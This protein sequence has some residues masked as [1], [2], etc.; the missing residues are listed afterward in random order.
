MCA[1]FKVS[2]G[3]HLVVRCIQAAEKADDGDT[4]P[5][6]NKLHRRK[7]WPRSLLSFLPHGAALTVQGL[8]QWLS[9]SPNA[10]VRSS[11]F[12]S[13]NSLIYIMHSMVITHV[14]VSRPFLDGIY[15]LNTAKDSFVARHGQFTREEE[16]HKI[17]N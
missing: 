13:I 17:S 6:L 12:N 7:H 2:P 16:E 14:I 15:G 4:L 5:P 1:V 3:W 10:M 11:L 9:C 8:Y